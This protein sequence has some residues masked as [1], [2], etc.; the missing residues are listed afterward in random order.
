MPAPDDRTEF[1]AMGG[2]QA[3]WATMGTDPLMPERPTT[4][5]RFVIGKIHAYRTPSWSFSQIPWG[6]KLRDM[7]AKGDVW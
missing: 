4:A 3:Q 1:L 5:G 7:K 6:T 2:A